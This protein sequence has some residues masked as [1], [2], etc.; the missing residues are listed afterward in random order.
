MSRWTSTYIKG[1]RMWERCDG[2]VL[3]SSD[4]IQAFEDYEEQ[5]YK[6]IIEKN[7]NCYNNYE[8]EDY[9]S[10]E[11]TEWEKE[12]PILSFFAP[13]ILLAVIFGIYFLISMIK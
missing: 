10:E 5:E 12:H 7:S 4:Q 1:K 2:V 9:G 13:F 6:K 8:E 3:A 11:L